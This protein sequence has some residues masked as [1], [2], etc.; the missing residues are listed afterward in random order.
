MN[1]KVVLEASEEGGFTVYVPSF[2]GCISEGE[3]EEEALANIREA[4]E[5][6]L[7]IISQK[8]TAVRIFP[9]FRGEF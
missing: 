5:L 4:I 6:Y 2:P 9:C 3:T 8:S 1:I 7:A